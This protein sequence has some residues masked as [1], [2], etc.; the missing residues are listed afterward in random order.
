MKTAYFD[1]NAT[2]E[3]SVPGITLE[4]GAENSG[5][6]LDLRAPKD[7]VSALR[8]YSGSNDRFEFRSLSPSLGD[9]VYFSADGKEHPIIQIEITENGVPQINLIG[10][11]MVDSLEVTDRVSLNNV[12]I[13]GTLKYAN[14]P[15]NQGRDKVLTY[16]PGNGVVGLD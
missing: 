3:N 4:G 16:D 11:V 5:T 1:R 7:N 10:K 13:K 8:L 2:K 6:F 12:D 15:T 9:I 14:P